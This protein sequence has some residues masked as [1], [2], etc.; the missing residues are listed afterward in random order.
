MKLNHLK[1]KISKFKNQK[2]IFK[3]YLETSECCYIIKKEGE[4]NSY[5]DKELKRIQGWDQCFFENTN[6]SK[7]LRCA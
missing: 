7:N 5:F 6:R 2:F 3:N 1:D 4:A